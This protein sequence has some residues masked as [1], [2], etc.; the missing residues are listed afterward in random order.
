[1]PSGLI[2]KDTPAS[3]RQV[4]KSAAKEFEKSIMMLFWQVNFLEPMLQE[5]H[6]S[7]TFLIFGGTDPQ[8][9]HPSCRAVYFAVGP[10]T[11]PRHAVCEVLTALLHL[12]GDFKG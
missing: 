4:E 12:K 8:G 3:S 7:V 2:L 9:R 5:Q 10:S 1:M 6:T 11:D